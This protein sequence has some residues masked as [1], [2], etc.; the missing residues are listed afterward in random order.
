LFTAEQLLFEQEQQLGKVE[1]AL[2][3]SFV[4]G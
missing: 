3:Y 4:Y 1:I 2:K